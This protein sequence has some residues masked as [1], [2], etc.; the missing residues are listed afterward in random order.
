M[1]MVGFILGFVVICCQSAISLKLCHID[2]AIDTARIFCSIITQEMR[3][4]SILTVSSR[5]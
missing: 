2:W 1:S 4:M 3:S 5:R